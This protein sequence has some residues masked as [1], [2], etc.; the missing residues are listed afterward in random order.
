VLADPAICRTALDELL[1]AYGDALCAARAL[2]LVRVVRV[3][4]HE[5][6]RP[7]RV[8]RSRRLVVRPIV[9]SELRRHIVVALRRLSA[10][11]DERW[12]EC[13]DGAAARQ[14]AALRARV[15]EARTALDHRSLGRRL[16]DHVPVVPVLGT[17]IAAWLFSPP[18]GRPDVE[19]LY[20]AVVGVMLLLQGRAIV[21]LLARPFGAQAARALLR[22]GELDLGPSA[23]L[24]SPRRAAERLVRWPFALSRNVLALEDR[25]HRMC[26]LPAPR[27]FPR[28]LVF[29]GW[30]LAAVGSLGAVVVGVLLQEDGLVFLVI[31]AVSVLCS[32]VGTWSLVVVARRRAAA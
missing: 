1:G 28:D 25:A 22:G 29:T 7:G 6:S 21:T 12:M 9:H 32:V 17:L 31:G 30:H 15:V 24:A 4:E 16:L 26:G 11:L 13:D 27:R 5:P 2:P 20:A 10:G 23:Y 8:D 3:E 14:R 19:H 18:G